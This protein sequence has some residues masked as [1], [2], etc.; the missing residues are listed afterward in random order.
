M[1]LVVCFL[2][3]II[4]FEEGVCKPLQIIWGQNF[5]I[6]STDWFF[7]RLSLLFSKGAVSTGSHFSLFIDEL[8]VYE[9]ELWLGHKAFVGGR[10]WESFVGDFICFHETGIRGWRFD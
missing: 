9:P 7:A 5:A 6:F 10:S 8:V 2:G 1:L 4:I 3:V